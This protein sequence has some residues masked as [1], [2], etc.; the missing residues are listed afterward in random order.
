MCIRDRDSTI[1]IVE[2]RIHGL[3]LLRSRLGESKI[4]F[5]QNGGY[6]LLFDSYTLSKD[7]L[8]NLNEK[9]FGLFNQNIF[10]FR[11]DLVYKFGFDQVH[12]LIQNKFEGQIHTGKMM[13]SLIEKAKSLG[14]NILTGSEVIEINDN[15]KFVEVIVSNQSINEKIKFISSKVSV[16]NNAFAKKLFKTLPLKPARGQVMITSEISNLKFKGTFHFDKGFYYFRN[17]GNRVL[18]GGGRNTDI[19]NEESFDFVENLDILSTLKKYLTDI[20]LPNNN[21]EI[22]MNWQGIMGFSEN[23][24]PIVNNVSTNVFCAF[25]CN[26]MGVA[27]GSQIGIEMAFLMNQII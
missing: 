10:S 15:E 17:V 25:G 3:E 11:N 8:N 13:K 1:A 16:C 26:G 22:E 4:G 2:K 23:K 24:L 27:L 6:E 18:I 5:E 7:K 9:L 12:S 19:T 20:I 14:V 21:F